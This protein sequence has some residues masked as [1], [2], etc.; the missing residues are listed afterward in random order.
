METRAERHR[1]RRDAPLDYVTHRAVMNGVTIDVTECWG[2]GEAESELAY[3][4]HTR[5]TALLS[6]TGARPCEPRLKRGRPCSEDYRPRNLQFA[7]AGQRL[8]GY[9]ADTDF[10][11]DVTLVVSDPAI[12]ARL[13]ARLKLGELPTRLRFVDDRIW[14][15]LRL[16]ADAIQSDEP[17]ERLWA[18]HLV[19]A[20]LAQLEG[21][22]SEPRQG[23]ALAPWR[24]RRAIALMEARMPGHVSLEELAAEVELSQA[25][26]SRAFK[27]STGLAP[28]QWQMQFRIRQALSLLETTKLSV[29][30]I[31]LATGFADTGH[32]ARRF[33]KATGLT[34]AA[35]R[36]ERMT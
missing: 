28:Y 32:F 13:G 3:E 27:D 21:Q 10:I 6:E 24:L 18:D 14:T 31:G 12:E 11:R 1:R 4:G 33:R 29:E 26:F 19:L 5:V 22:M 7:S 15:P 2:I 36:R 30:A 16:L 23:V 17:F 35:W 34:P 25:H 20:V 9:C 8:W